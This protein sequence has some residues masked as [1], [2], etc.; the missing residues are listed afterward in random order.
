MRR[1]KPRER[2]CRRVSWLWASWPSGSPFKFRELRPQENLL[3]RTIR[4]NGDIRS[5]TDV[6]RGRARRKDGVSGDSDLH[7]RLAREPVSLL[8]WRPRIG[9]PDLRPVL[10]LEP[11]ER[12][13]RSRRGVRGLG[14]PCC[15][16]RLGRSEERR[17]GKECRSRGSPYH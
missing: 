16:D 7:C 2:R 17:V 9:M 1:K 14:G 11:R 15:L 3:S 5:E 10:T 4:S 8:A 13:D 12:P 6:I